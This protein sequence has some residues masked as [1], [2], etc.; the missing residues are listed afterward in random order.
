M[1]LVRHSGLYRCYFKSNQAVTQ[2]LPDVLTNICI[3]IIRTALTTVRLHAN[4]HRKYLTVFGLSLTTL[5]KQEM[6]HRHTALPDTAL[7]KNLTAGGQNAEGIDATNDLSFLCIQASMHTQLPAPSFSVRI[8]NGTPNEFLIKCAELTRT[9]VGLLA[10]YNDEV[11]IPAIYASRVLLCR[12]EEYGIIGCV[13]QKKPFKTD[14]GMTRHS[15]IC[16]VRLNLCSQT[17][18]IRALKSVSR[19]AMLKI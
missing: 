2:F 3:R 4:L 7:S 1:R 10:Y 5:I 14:G 11:I 6:R 16:A 8:W 18:L 19:Q 12:C 13:E 15:L 17:V 9:G